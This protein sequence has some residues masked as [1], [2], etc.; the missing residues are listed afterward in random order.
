MGSLK[1]VNLRGEPAGSDR[2]YVI[3]VV[4]TSWV[5]FGISSDPERR[6]K[7]LQ[8]GNPMELELLYVIGPFRDAMKWEKRI[9]S[10]LTADGLHVRGEWFIVHPGDEVNIL[11]SVG[12]RWVT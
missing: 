10:V 6:M 8:T 5:K 9:H 1:T 11:E 12:F 4:G 3:R 7:S 2:L